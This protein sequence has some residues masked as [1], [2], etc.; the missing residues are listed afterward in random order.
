MAFRPN[1]RAAFPAFG[2]KWVNE[3]GTLTESARASLA[4]MFLRQGG[5]T[6]AIYE[7]ELQLVDHASRM[8]GF[9][10]SLEGL[11]DRLTDVG[12]SVSDIERGIADLLENALNT[13][14][15]TETA[16]L[17]NIEDALEAALALLAQVS[18]VPG[19]V[20]DRIDELERQIEELDIALN[21]VRAAAAPESLLSGIAGVELTLDSPLGISSGGT[22]SSTA[23]TARTALGVAIGS[24]VLAYNAYA[25]GMDQD[26]DTTATPTFAGM[27]STGFLRLGSGS[28]LSIDA[29][30]TVTA[31]ESWHLVDTYLGGGTSNLSTINGG[32]EGALLVIS[33]VANTRDVVVKDATGNINLSGGDRTL[34][35]VQDTLTL[36]KRGSTWR[37]LSF[38]DNA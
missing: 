14:R 25:D 4:M 17:S 1:L 6:D 8:D 29:S 36:I 7:D 24:D 28:T 19:D 11:G 34:D 30:D 16:D 32:S 26:V 15:A 2:A 35:T 23:A 22:G 5:E 33:T 3:D 37:E 31:T 38:A 13:V 18:P 10:G 12:N 21:S 27:I 9:D 20:T